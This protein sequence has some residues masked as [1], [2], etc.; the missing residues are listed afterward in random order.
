MTPDEAANAPPLKKRRRTRVTSIQEKTTYTCHHAGSYKPQHSSVL[1]EGRLRMNTKKTVKCNC[2]SKVVLTVMQSGECKVA[3][4]WRH[5]GHGM[6][7]S[8]G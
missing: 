1:P 6:F 2:P 3:Y 8:K 4:Y 5:V 7:M